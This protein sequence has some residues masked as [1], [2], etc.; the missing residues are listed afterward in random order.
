VDRRLLALA[1]VAATAC[2]PKVAVVPPVP[3][4]PLH[5]E[6]VFPVVPEGTTDAQAAL[7]DFGW[8][9]LQADNLR[10][11]ERSFEEALTRQPQ[12]HPAE[13]GLG[14]VLLAG[15]EAKDAV[16]HFDRALA[17]SANYVPA[18]VGR[19]QALLELNRDGDALASLEAAVKAD[20]SL[21]NLKGRID[22]LRFRAL[23][24]SLARAKAAADAARWDEARTAYEQA[25]KASPESPFL[26]RD[27]GLVE[28][29]AGETAAALEHFRKTVELDPNDARA[30]AQIGAILDEQND[31]AAALAAYERARELDPSE[32]SDAAINRVRELTALAKLPAEYRAIPAAP[33]ATRADIAALI[34]VRLAPLV[35]Q[36][37]ER[38]VVIT[39]IRNN[40]AQQWIVP[41]VRAGIMDTQPN[42]T[43][44]PA[45]RVR[46]GDLAQTAARVLGLIATH[47][48]A[49]AKAWE[50][51]TPKISDVSPSHLSYAAVSQAVASGVM[52]LENGAFQ[53][54]RAVTGA[55]AAAVIARLE[56]L[57]QP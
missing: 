18:L 13:T 16:T 44:Q 6:F 22:L 43:F 3:T 41:V 51:T 8:R 34:G 15:R 14:Y 19:G 46:R 28:R 52:P 40:W 38:Q 24:D 20:P 35:A 57:A 50:S 45:S 25:I 1:L 4:T 33:L 2:A 30:H 11:A 47:Y 53:L 56:A 10:T 5:P 48:P 9:Y 29:K 42:Y 49:R 17:Q 36:A 32:V 31:P 39:D 21:T 12:F 27:L 54:L 55:E 7:I 26:Y 37:R 23:Q